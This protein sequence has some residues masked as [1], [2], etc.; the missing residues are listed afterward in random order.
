MQKDGL[1]YS[2]GFTDRFTQDKIPE[3]LDLE[4]LVKRNN[5]EISYLSIPLDEDD[6]HNQISY[7][8]DEFHIHYEDENGSTHFK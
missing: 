6:A 5:N 7:Q 1:E 3:T 2:L 4:K 8:D